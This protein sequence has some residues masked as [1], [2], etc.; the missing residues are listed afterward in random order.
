MLLT[1]SLRVFLVCLFSCATLVL[2]IIWFG[3]QHEAPEL[4]KTTASLFVVGL[5]S[6]LVWFVAFAL[7]FK[8]TLWDTLEVQH[9][10]KSSEGSPRSA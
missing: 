3:D 5:A 7:K 4:F 10:S 9:T 2:Y 6:F 1:I 8:K